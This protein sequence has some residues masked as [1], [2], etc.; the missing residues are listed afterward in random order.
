MDPSQHL[1]S[2]FP[3]LANPLKVLETRY[4]GFAEMPEGRNV[5]AVMGMAG[6]TK[7]IWDPNNKDEVEA[8]ETMYKTLTKKGYRA[9]HVTGKDGEKGELMT[10]FD[11]K[12]GKVIFVGA[13]VGG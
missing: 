2:K 12:A 10:S 6:D 8:A 5:F 3:D 13:L 4:G 9:F 11:P 7:S 1:I